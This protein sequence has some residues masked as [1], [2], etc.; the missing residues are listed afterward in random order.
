MKPSSRNALSRWWVTP[1]NW[2]C[3]GP[4]ICTCELYATA[5]S[6]RRQGAA[7]PPFW[8]ATRVR[9]M[10]PS[11]PLVFPVWGPQKRLF[12]PFK[13][14]IW[15]WLLGQD[16][17]AGYWPTIL[18]SRLVNSAYWLVTQNTTTTT[19]N[20]NNNVKKAIL[21]RACKTTTLHEQHAFLLFPVLANKPNLVKFLEYVNRKAINFT[22]SI[23]ARE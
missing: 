12:C 10:G 11:C 4:V 19:A 16:G 6:A 3:W 8:L 2:L 22:E 21:H 7:N 15:S 17:W 13:K 9:K 1:K 5:G 23:W 14:T 18:I 20:E